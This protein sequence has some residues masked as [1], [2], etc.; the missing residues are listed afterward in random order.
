MGGFRRQD[1]LSLNAVRAAMNHSLSMS[2]G[3]A[4]LKSRKKKREIALF[5]G[6]GGV[7]VPG[8]QVV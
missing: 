1:G 2:S 4:L 8:H 3:C 7:R 6:L 5:N